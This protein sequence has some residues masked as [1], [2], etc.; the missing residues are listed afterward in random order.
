MSK[1]NQNPAA[2]ALKASGLRSRANHEVKAEPR[3]KRVAVIARNQEVQADGVHRLGVAA[4]LIEADGVHRLGVAAG[5]IE[6]DGVHRLGVAVGLIEA[7]EVHRLGEANVESGQ[8]Q[9]KVSALA[10]QAKPLATVTAENKPL[11]RFAKLSQLAR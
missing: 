6:A 1:N 5:L 10:N 2:R 8:T 4:G 11:P 9:R 7:D 3:T